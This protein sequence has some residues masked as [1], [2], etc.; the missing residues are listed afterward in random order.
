M[1]W[2][3]LLALVFLAPL[4]LALSGPTTVTIP[5]PVVE[6]EGMVPN[7]LYRVPYEAFGG[8]PSKLM[9]VEIRM[10]T[11]F[12]GSWYGVE[13]LCSRAVARDEYAMSTYHDMAVATRRDHSYRVGYSMQAGNVD[14]DLSAFNGTLDHEGSSAWG[15]SYQFALSDIPVQAKPAMVADFLPREGGN[16]LL[17]WDRQRWIVHDLPP[18]WGGDGYEGGHPLYSMDSTPGVARIRAELF[19]IV[20]VE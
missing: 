7:R 2:L 9:G 8:D 19:W 11:G 17:L 16:E 4:A 5:G 13:N 18:E 10:S 12:E 15:W 1:K 20:E 3:P 6:V 14:R